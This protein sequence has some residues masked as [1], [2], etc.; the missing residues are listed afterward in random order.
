M[1]KSI[2]VYVVVSDKDI[3][4]DIPSILVG[5]K[6]DISTLYNYAVLAVFERKQ[7]AINWKKK[8]DVRSIH[9]NKKIVRGMLTLGT[10]GLTK[11]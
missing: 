5:R 3:C 11:G 9:S 8:C 2:K 1:K 10:R 7:A 4:G 6:Y